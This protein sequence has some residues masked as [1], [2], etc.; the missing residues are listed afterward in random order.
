MFDVLKRDLVLTRVPV[1]KPTWRRMTETFANDILD[2][3][4]KTY[5]L[6]SFT[7]SEIFPVDIVI[8]TPNA[9]RLH[10]EVNRSYENYL[11]LFRQQHFICQWPRAAHKMPTTVDTWLSWIRASWY[12]Y[13]NNQQDALYRLIYYSNSALHVSTTVVILQI[14]F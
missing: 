2:C 7:L 10:R 6:F 14:D 12:N 11:T 4:I 3:N 8:T 5:I 9:P 1:S 13:E